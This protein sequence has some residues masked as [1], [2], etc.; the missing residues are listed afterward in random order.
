MIDDYFK[1]NTSKLLGKLHE[2]EK[3]VKLTYI[4]ERG[5]CEERADIISSMA[6]DSYLDSL[7]SGNPSVYIQGCIYRYA[8]LHNS[9]IA[10]PRINDD[11]RIIR[12]ESV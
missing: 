11:G 5:L 3:K 2:I 12:I 1:G 6:V 9:R 8:R 4:Y 10:K 7:A